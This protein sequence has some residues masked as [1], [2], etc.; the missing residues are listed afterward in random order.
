M[1]SKTVSV[2]IPN[3]NYGRYL[4]EAIKSVLN[5]S[6]SEIECIVVNNGSTD[7]SLEV[8][9]Q[10]KSQ[11]TLIDQENRGQSGARNAGLAIAQGE[12]IAFLD[13]DDY[14]CKDKIYLQLQFL[15]DDTELVYCGISK[16]SDT[17]RKEIDVLSPKYRGSC[18]RA[19]LDNPGVSIVLSGESTALFSRKLLQKVGDF[20]S[21]LNS[22]AGWDF[23]RRASL[24]TEF[25]YVD[26]PLTNYRVHDGNMSKLILS[27]IEDIRLAYTKLFIDEDWKVGSNE[28]KRVS[29]ALELTFLKTYLKILDFPHATNSLLR[30][31]RHKG[32]QNWN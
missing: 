22:A 17:T 30:M 16:F 5:Q 7:N 15:N 19:F 9:H 29:L 31:L 18:S 2:I 11:I 6:H 28:A 8:L 24:F 3:Y 27:N 25:N 23:F 13:A 10:F 4:P 32:Y 1:A 12:Y 21:H 14:W 20:D 26:S